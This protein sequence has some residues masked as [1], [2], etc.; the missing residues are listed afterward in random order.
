MSQMTPAQIT[1]EINKTSNA[2]YN[3]AGVRPEF[4]RPPYI[5]ISNTMYETIDLPFICGISCN[6]WESS[7]SAEAR[8]ATI[9]NSARDGDIV[10]LHDFYGNTQTVDALDTMIQG[11]MDKGFSFVTVSQLF[12][13]K[14]V[15]PNVK[16]RLWTNVAN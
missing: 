8:A 9:L 7:I 13:Q 2:I 1:D 16:Y 4:F 11:L 3:A 14:N 12:E 5:S 15:N 6:D 10:L